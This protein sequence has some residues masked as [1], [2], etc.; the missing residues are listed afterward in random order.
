[1]GGVFLGRRKRSKTFPF[2][3]SFRSLCEP[4]RPAERQS[5]DTERMGTCLG[6][7]PIA[8]ISFSTRSRRLSMRSRR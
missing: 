1:M 5:L 7:D 4:P 3:P 2:L 8:G 6:R